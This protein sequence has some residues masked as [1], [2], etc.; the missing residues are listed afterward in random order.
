MCSMFWEHG[1]EVTVLLSNSNNEASH[2]GQTINF[3]FS[4]YLLD[5]HFETIARN[6]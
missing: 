6:I 4:L 3:D 5:E 1:Y 2:I